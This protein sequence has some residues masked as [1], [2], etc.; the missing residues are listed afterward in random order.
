VVFIPERQILAGVPV[1]S[2]ADLDRRIVTITEPDAKVM[3]RT[4][5]L[6]CAVADAVL[7][8]LWRPDLFAR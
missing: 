8:R 5:A 3:T 6:R 2:I 4:L 1:G 7:S